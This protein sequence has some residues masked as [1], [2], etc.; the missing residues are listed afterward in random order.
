[1]SL[2]I[3]NPANPSQT[4]TW[5]QKGKRANWVLEG[6]ANGTIK[7]P[8]EY[9]DRK[10]MSEKKSSEPTEKSITEEPGLKAWKYVGE[11]DV[12]P[13]LN[14]NIPRCVIVAENMGEAIRLFNRTTRNPV[15]K[16]EFVNFWKQISNEE[17]TLRDKPSVYEMKD[18]LWIIRK[19][20]HTPLVIA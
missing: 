9:A 7:M 15:T 11:L 6:L 8:Q 16:H 1:M 13:R 19:E 20:L 4:F 2:T 3:T 12:D 14:I 5:G 10:L 17:F 18:S